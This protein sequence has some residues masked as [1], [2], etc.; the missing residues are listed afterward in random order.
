MITPQTLVSKAASLI[1]ALAIIPLTI[2]AS[3]A[4][5]EMTIQGAMYGKVQTLADPGSHCYTKGPIDLKSAVT[6][7]CSQSRRDDYCIYT[8]PWPTPEEDPGY[9]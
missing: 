5:A 3:V 6:E 8:V 9:G 2:L 7:F 1:L 4:S